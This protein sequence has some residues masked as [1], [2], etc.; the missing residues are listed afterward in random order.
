MHALTSRD[1]LWLWE[2]G[3]ALHAID[4]ALHVLA[5]AYPELG[6]EEL[7]ALPLSERDRL[8]LAVRRATIGNR[9]EAC[10]ACPACGERIEVELSCDTLAEAGAVAPQQW[11]LEHAGYRLRLRALTSADAA[12]AARCGEVAS[13]RSVLLARSIVAA[14]MSG[15]QQSAES[16]PAEV[17]AAVADSIECHDS[18]VEL[19]LALNCPAC[20]HTWSN[21]LDVASFVWTEIVARAQRLLV[22]VHTLAGAYGWREADILSLGEARRAAYLSMVNA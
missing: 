13:A 3:A 22:D 18:G 5:C 15:E 4:R 14:E 2:R 19:L 10:D 6:G 12:M 20:G 9:L 11:E 16:L 1:I 7:I 17:L 8:L 21:A